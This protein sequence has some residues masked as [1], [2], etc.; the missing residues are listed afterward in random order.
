[1]Q[2]VALIRKQMAAIRKDLPVLI[3]LGER[4]ARLIL[5]GG[6]LFPA[7]VAEF[8]PNEFTHRA[9]GLMGINASNYEATSER[10]VAFFALPGKAS[11]DPARD[12]KLQGLIRGKARLFAIGRR[13][14]LGSLRAGGRFA[15]FT[16]GARPSEGLYAFGS[17]KPLAPLWQFDHLV[18]GWMTTGE[19]IAACTRA[20]RMPAIWMSVWLEGAYVRNFSFIQHDN[21]I[22]PWYPPMFHAKHYVPP[23]APGYAGNAF[24]ADVDRIVSVLEA[25]SARLA[26]AGAWIAQ[27]VKAGRKVHVVAVGHSYPKL[28]DLPE[29][30]AYPVDWSGSRSD[31]SK[32]VP[33][34][35]GRGDVAV[36]LGYSP[37]NVT[38]VG[39][40]LGR[41]IRFIYTSPYGRPAALKSHRN[42]LWLDLPWRPGD[43]AVDV[44]GY[45]VRILPLSSS[46][47]TVA[48]FA[49]LCEMAHRLGGR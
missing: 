26:K 49:M 47:H 31:L 18:R 30:A 5:E 37:V 11:W 24:L 6:N 16:G 35:L 22:E 15:G 4:M 3:R 14:R 13:D 8:W 40:I 12:E 36:H 23:L 48:Y 34:R 33:A 25:Q 42:L 43:A 9:G 44:P 29:G 1:M 10:D 45:S 2:Y 27:A 19:M 17:I 38:H 41:G 32:A 20:G 7:A 28:L 46:A 39:R 21:L